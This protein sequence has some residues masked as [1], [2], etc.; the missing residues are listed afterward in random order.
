MILQQGYVERYD[1]VTI[2]WGRFSFL[3]AVFVVFQL[4]LAKYLWL[5]SVFR[6]VAV[7]LIAIAFTYTLFAVLSSGIATWVWAVIALIVL[8]ISGLVVVCEANR[9]DQCAM[10]YSGLFSLVLLLYII[11]VA[12]SPALFYVIDWCIFEWA[13]VFVDILLI[14]NSFLL[15]CTYFAVYKSCK[16][17]PEGCT[18]DPPCAKVTHSVH[19]HAQ[20]TTGGCDNQC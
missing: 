3:I 15:A 6:N 17:I 10:I 7:A 5:H 8:V 11:F 9:K 14:V 16:E 19:L 20:Y 4:I 1:G 2:P 18:A 13:I 12:L